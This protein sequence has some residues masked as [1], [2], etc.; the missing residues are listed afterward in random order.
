MWQDWG[1]LPIR[2]KTPP[3]SFIWVALSGGNGGNWKNQ[4]DIWMEE[5]N[6]FGGAVGGEGL[7]VAIKGGAGGVDQADILENNDGTSFGKREDERGDVTLKDDEEVVY[8]GGEVGDDGVPQGEGED[9]NE[10]LHAEGGEGD[11]EEVLHEGGC[12]CGTV[13]WRVR[14]ARL[15][16][17]ETRD[18]FLD[19]K[20]FFSSVEC[21]CSDERSIIC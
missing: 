4:R 2:W 7:N 21:S 13:R 18:T 17:G 5:D 15:P 10:V 3:L 8:G 11:K 1:G 14:A 20:T 6:L 16:T 9:K 19:F 12:H